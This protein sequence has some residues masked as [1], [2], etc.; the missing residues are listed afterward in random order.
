MRTEITYYADDGTEFDTE[1]ECLAYEKEG[2]EALGS[3]LC[4]DEEMKPLTMTGEYHD[5]YYIFIVDADRSRTL[6]ERIADQRGICLPTKASEYS[7]GDV[8]MYDEDGSWD[9]SWLNLNR[10][11]AD[12]AQKMACVM[13]EVNNNST[14]R[15]ATQ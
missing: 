7:N 8:L 2:E 4:F 5:P 10:I 13:K 15:E 11:V 3:V 6:F 9:D 14:T 1:D 12:Y